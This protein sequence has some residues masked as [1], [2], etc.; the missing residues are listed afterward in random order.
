MNILHVQLS[1]NILHTQHINILHV[2]LSMNILHTQHNYEHI[3]CTA[4][5]EHITYSALHFVPL[6]LFDSKISWSLK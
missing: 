6:A 5:H 4:Q 1:M 2:Q 3:T